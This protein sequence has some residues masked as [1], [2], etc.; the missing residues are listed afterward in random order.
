MIII[1]LK[2]CLHIVSIQSTCLPITLGTMSL[3]LLTQYSLLFDHYCQ[4][5]KQSS[6]KVN[7]PSSSSVKLEGPLPAFI[8]AITL[9]LHGSSGISCASNLGTLKWIQISSLW[10]ITFKYFFK[11]S[12]LTFNFSTLYQQLSQLLLSESYSFRLFK[13][14]GG[15]GRWGPAGNP[16]GTRLASSLLPHSLSGQKL[17]A[18]HRH[19]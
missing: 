18:A 10:W 3:H 4:A 2:V 12:S 6:L 8:L 7:K 13:L 5:I 19:I 9:F 14:A 16:Q 1:K 17:W 11:I 15:G